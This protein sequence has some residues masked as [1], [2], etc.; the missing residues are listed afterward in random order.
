[1]IDRFR[2]PRLREFLRAASESGLEMLAKREPAAVMAAKPDVDRSVTSR[3]TSG[4]THPRFHAGTSKRRLHPFR[5]TPNN[6]FIP[7]QSGVLKKRPDIV[8]KSQTA[9][10]SRKLFPQALTTK[11]FQTCM[12]NTMDK[13]HLHFDATWYLWLYG[14]VHELIAQGKWSSG[15][16]HYLAIGSKEGR[17]PNPVMDEGW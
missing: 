7:A 15:L 16:E 17:S 11:T 8:N 13:A 4:T 6:R 5:N 14:D 9:C 3:T 12:S 10:L 1:M 2:N